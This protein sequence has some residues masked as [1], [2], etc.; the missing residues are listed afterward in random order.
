MG[1]PA[2]DM[3][4]YML[5]KDADRITKWSLLSTAP[6]SHEAQTTEAGAA[7]FIPYVILP[8]ALDTG[9]TCSGG[10]SIARENKTWFIHQVSVLTGT[11]IQADAVG[12]TH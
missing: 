3:Q 7:S 1:D 4:L 11:P 2:P 10:S 5:E 12:N 8:S 9:F 6:F